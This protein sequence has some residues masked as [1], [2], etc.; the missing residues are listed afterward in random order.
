MEQTGQTTA[1]ELV[2]LAGLTDTLSGEGEFS[3][4]VVETVVT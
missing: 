3:V 4:E 2:E 1:L